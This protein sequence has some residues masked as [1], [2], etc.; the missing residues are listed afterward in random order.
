MGEGYG[1]WERGFVEG[2]GVWE[3]VEG[4]GYGR[5][6]WERGHIGAR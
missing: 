1:R 3:R 2:K 4:E 5:G 6:V